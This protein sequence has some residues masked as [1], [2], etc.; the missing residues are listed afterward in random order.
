MVEQLPRRERIRKKILDRCRTVFS[1]DWETLN[2]PCWIWQGGTSG[3]GRGGGYGRLRLDGGMVAT[4]RAMFIVEHGP[5]PSR[6]Q[7]DHK[8]RNRLCCNP[9]HL[10]MVTHKQNQMRRDKAGRGEK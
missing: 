6:K 10:E 2:G 9:A 5:I 7:I 1:E 3:G 8:C 4:H